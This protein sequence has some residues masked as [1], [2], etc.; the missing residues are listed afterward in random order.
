MK[1]DQGDPD[2]KNLNSGCHICNVGDIVIA[3]SDGIHDNLDPVNTGKTPK[4][5]GIETKSNYWHEVPNEEETRF[6]Y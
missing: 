6:F 4:D 1:G 5:L 2:L 3:V